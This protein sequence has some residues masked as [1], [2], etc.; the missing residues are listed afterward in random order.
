MAMFFRDG[1]PRL[2]RWTNSLAQPFRTYTIHATSTSIARSS[3]GPRRVMRQLRLIVP[4]SNCFGTSP[5]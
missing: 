1:T 3:V 2:M 4:L 5:A